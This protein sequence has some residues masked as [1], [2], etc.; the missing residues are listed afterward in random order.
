MKY[1]IVS[2]IPGRLRV[3]C[4]RYV[5]DEGQARAVSFYLSE[6]PHVIAAFANPVTGSILITY[7]YDGDVGPDKV[8][9]ALLGALEEMAID[10]LPPVDAP[11]AYELGLD[12]RKRLYAMILKYAAARIFLPRRA[13]MLLSIARS[14]GFI[15]KAVAVLRRG[16]VGVEVLD[17]A[18]IASSFIS[19]NA[20][21]AS[22]IM[23]L[24]TVS[25]LL[26]GYTRTRTKDALSEN[27]IL[28][29]DSVWVERDGTRENIP[30]ADLKLHDLVVVGAGSVL[31]VDGTVVAGEA[32]V[33]Q[34]SMTG[35]PIPIRRTRLDSVF[36]GT[37]VT[38][39]S[40]TVEVTALAQESRIS[41]IVELIDT[42]DRLKASV[43]GKAER[44]ADRIVPFSFLFAAGVFLL[45]RSVEKALAVLLVD[46]SCAI[47]LA[48][49]ISIIS[50]MREAAA[51]RIMVGGGKFLEA[52]AEASVVIFD[53]T[54]TLTTSRPA[55]S[56]V[57]PFEGFTRE[58]VL[59]AAAC[60][61]EHF[62]HSVARAVIR[63]AEGEGLT[64]EE[65]HA[66]P[67]YIVA[68]GVAAM[69]RNERVVIGSRHFVEEDEHIAISGEERRIIEENAGGDSVLYLGVAGKAAGIICVSDPP[70]K[71]AADVIRELKAS[72]IDEIVMLTG[73]GE[74]TAK[75][76]CDELGIEKYHAQ[77]L[78]EDKAK[79]VE[80]Y[81]SDGRTVMMVGDGINDAPALAAANVSVAMRDSSDIAQETADIVLL[82]SDLMALITLRR[83]SEAMMRR[84][85]NNFR[86]I[87]T[88]N[89]ACLALGVGEI[90]SPSATA[91]LHNSSSMAFS[92]ASMRNYR[93]E[94]TN[95]PSIA[96]LTHAAPGGVA[97]A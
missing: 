55:V 92:A 23:F 15:K 60:L 53:K 35:E 90:L 59:C 18:A 27:L 66:E 24:L 17:V 6:L 61:E 77:V 94:N 8:R 34:S 85:R 4:G 51:R 25:D 21:T 47:K 82:D 28:H 69:F 37:V 88:F 42:N 63:Q 26:D 3:R 31:P 19:D 72:G 49:P 20:D 32:T 84:V 46:Y 76:V 86:G 58:D 38:E 57:I 5:F 93:V 91:L 78:P 13:R 33:D 16:K 48:T 7:I 52:A 45:T 73:D 50:A 12:F 79:I 43:Q 54:G 14:I 81:K 2:D 89:T 68:H 67:E 29:V 75:A 80:N 95:S 22:S 74:L 11:S 65:I 40:L 10:D 96:D 70:R 56:K 71:E 1:R 44:I 41:R 36:A 64:H 62:P 30:L 97:T 83:L 9:A 87:V 39:G